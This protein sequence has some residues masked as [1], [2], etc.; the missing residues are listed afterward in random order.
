MKKGGR[1]AEEIAKQIRKAL[2]SSE[3]R[4]GDRLPPERDLA[5]VFGTSPLVVRE[6]LHT[7]EFDGLLHIRNGAAGGAIVIEPSHRPVTRSLTSWLRFGRATLEQLTEARLL[8]EP[9]VARLA[10]LRAV[11]KDFEAFDAVLVERRAAVK[12]G[13]PGQLL[14]I[15]FHRAVAEAAKNPVHLV[16][17]HALMDLEAEAVI[18]ALVL[19]ADDNTQVLR[20]HERI[21]EAI[22]RGEAARA[23]SLMTKHIRDVQRRLKDVE[24]HLRQNS[25]R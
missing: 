25:L 4:A 10:A 18:P 11:R 19:S 7:L 6:A 20:A 23:Q 22:R 1:L 15:Q 17:V 24:A 16:V 8:I 13:A 12:P 21:L 9:E 3:L 5:R 2:L 14:D